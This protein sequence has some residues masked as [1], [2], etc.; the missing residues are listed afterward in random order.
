[1]LYEVITIIKTNQKR[2]VKSKNQILRIYILTLIQQKNLDEA[3]NA[4]NELIKENNSNFVIT[5][6][7]IHYT[8]LYD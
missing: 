1:M 2:I 6:Y 3:L 7:S 4:T 5:S 8:K